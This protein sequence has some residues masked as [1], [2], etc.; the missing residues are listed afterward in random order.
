MRTCGL[1]S[2]GNAGFLTGSAQVTSSRLTCSRGLNV[3]FPTSLHYEHY[4]H[5]NWLPRSSTS[6]DWKMNSWKSYYWSRN[7]QNFKK[8]WQKVAIFVFFPTLANILF[9]S[10]TCF[11][12]KTSFPSKP[13][14]PKFIPGAQQNFT[15]A[16]RV[17]RWKKQMKSIKSNIK[18][19]KAVK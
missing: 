19:W 9:L 5:R 10:F 13:Q 14:A 4:L 15:K 17:S 2:S 12:F 6:R 16:M 18:K 7:V 11:L 3:Q 1:D 8:S